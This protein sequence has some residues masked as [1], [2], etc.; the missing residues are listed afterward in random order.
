MNDG[1]VLKLNWT[2]FCHYIDGVD[3]RI[4]ALLS[5][6]K[7]G[8]IIDYDMEELNYGTSLIQKLLEG[9]KELR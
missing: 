2:L 5:L 9:I 4:Q 1:D 7:L 8:I 6:K 3:K